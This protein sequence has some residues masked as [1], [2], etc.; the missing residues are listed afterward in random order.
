MTQTDSYG[1]FEVTTEV[2]ERALQ[3]GFVIDGKYEIKRLLGSGGSGS[4]Y[5]GEHATIG[6]RVA[7]KVVHTSHRSARGQPRSLST[8]GAICGAIRHPHVGQIY[9]VGALEDG[10]PFMV[11]ELHDGRSLGDVLHE[12]IA[13]HRRRD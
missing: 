8:R 10:A 12:S 7:I 2:R 9:D 6:H 4:V 1:D 5:E 11:M 13:A 3:A